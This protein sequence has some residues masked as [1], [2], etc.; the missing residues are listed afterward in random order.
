[1]KL[2]PIALAAVTI[3]YPFIVYF[4]LQHHGARALAIPLCV[5]ALL[6]FAI[7]RERVWAV[8]VLVTV[9]LAAATIVWDVSAPAK[10][11]PV[12]VNLGLL[13]VFA[14]SLTHPPS[15]AERIARVREPDLP[16]QA[17]T[18]TRRVTQVWCVYF[19]VNAAI[20][21]T[22]AVA[23]SDRAWTLYSGGIAY[24]AAGVLFAGEFLVRQQVRR[25]WGHA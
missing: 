10:L 5:I 6:R 4:I 12:A 18:Y 3:A 1:M 11:Y 15:V 25:K 16:P 19:V 8:V 24:A 14:H 13:A 21:G 17:V 23:A 20:A 9:A 22:L 2:R 7:G